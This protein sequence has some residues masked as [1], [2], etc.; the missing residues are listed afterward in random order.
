MLCDYKSDITGIR[1]RSSI[2]DSCYV[3]YIVAQHILDGPKL[4]YS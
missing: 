1:N 4:I 2:S 3:R